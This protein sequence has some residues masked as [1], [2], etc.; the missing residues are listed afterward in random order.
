MPH[1]SWR[2]WVTWLLVGNSVVWVINTVFFSALVF[3]GSSVAGLIGSSFFSKMTLLETGVAFLIGGALAF[4]GS[5]LPSKT[6]EQ[7]FKKGEPWSMEKL[8]KSE[9]RANKFIVLALVL[10]LE[11]LII[12]LFGV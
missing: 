8:K 6:Q 2:T 7:I 4:S 11:S 1:A 9:K 12:S 10:F 3:T 5:V